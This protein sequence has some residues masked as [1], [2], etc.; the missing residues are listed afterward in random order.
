MD[1]TL[2]ALGNNCHKLKTLE[3]ASCSQFTDAGF[4]ILAQVKCY[5]FHTT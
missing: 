3:A 5:G 1:A 4:K 2:I